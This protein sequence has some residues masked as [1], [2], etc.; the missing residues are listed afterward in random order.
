MDWGV[1]LAAAFLIL[2]KR[3]NIW[4]VCEKINKNLKKTGK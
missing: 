1:R 4:F 3:K 2:K